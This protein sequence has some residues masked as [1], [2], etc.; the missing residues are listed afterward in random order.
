MYPASHLCGYFFPEGDVVCAIFFA[1]AMI[2]AAEAE[3]D[4]VAAELVEYAA[5]A[6]FTDVEEGVDIDG[7]V[8]V[9]AATA[10]TGFTGV[11]A[12][13]AA[14]ATVMGS[15]QSGSHLWGYLFV[16]LAAAL[17]A[18]RI[19]AAASRLAAVVDFIAAA[20]T[21]SEDW[22]DDTRGACCCCSCLGCCETKAVGSSGTLV[23]AG[24]L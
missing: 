24:I 19:A 13:A 17:A 12:A 23:S 6:V 3:D 10:F 18:L 21:A 8:G 5:A 11:P 7:L 14:A 15:F 22:V 16:P 1:V 4:E 2:F 20:A 9:S